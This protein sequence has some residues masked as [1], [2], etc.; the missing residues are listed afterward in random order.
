M[1]SMLNFMFLIA[2]GMILTA[3]AV[4]CRTTGTPSFLVFKLLP[5]ILGIGSLTLGL[6]IFLE[7][8][9]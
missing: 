2:N 6:Y 8:S 5:S 4:A 1:V 9:L 7:K 3:F